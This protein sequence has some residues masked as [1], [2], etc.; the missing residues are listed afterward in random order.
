[1][2]IDERNINRLSWQYELDLLRYISI[3]MTVWK[4]VSFCAF[5]PAIV[6]MLAE[7]IDGSDIISVLWIPLKIYAIVWGISTAVLFSSYYLVF[8]PIHGGKY[9]ILFEMDHKGIKHIVAKQEMKKT[10]QVA[11]LG[12]F[13]GLFAR[14]PMVAGSSIIAGARNSMYTSFNCVTKIVIYSQ[15]QKIILIDSHVARNKIYTSPEDF[16]L[17]TKYIIRRC[18]SEVKKVYK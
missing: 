16:E 15:K 2:Q 14:N 8:V 13:I 1:M 4:I 11:L 18:K 3:I 5:L 12:I 6:V 9:R 7:F 10:R 17:V